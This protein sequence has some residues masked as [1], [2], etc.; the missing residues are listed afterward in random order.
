[1]SGLPLFEESKCNAHVQCIIVAPLLP[2]S[3]EGIKMIFA[4]PVTLGFPNIL[5]LF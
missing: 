5:S 1:M 2:S 4:N 3:S